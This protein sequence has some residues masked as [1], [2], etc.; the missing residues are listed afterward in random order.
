MGMQNST[1]QGSLKR[2]GFLRAT[3]GGVAGLA[4]V[5]ALRQPPAIAQQRELTVLSFNHFVPQ[6]DEEL[7]KQAAEFSKRNK[8]K[9]TVDT[10]A[11]LQLPAK[12]AA[13][14]QTGTGHDIV[15]LPRS[16]PYLYKRQ[17]VNLDDLAEWRLV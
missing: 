17:L 1:G 9:V 5:L 4:G 11:G 7:K 6:S 14:V 8:V 15:A 2:R 13:E 10:I 12:L 3:A 16:S